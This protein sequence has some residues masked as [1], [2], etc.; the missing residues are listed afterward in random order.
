VV[1]RLRNRHGNAM[2]ERTVLLVF[3]DPVGQ[4]TTSHVPYGYVVQLIDALRRA[5]VRSIS[6]QGAPASD[7]G[8]SHSLAGLLLEPLTVPRVTVR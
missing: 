8:G 7:Q 5:G 1:T 2:T 6:L 4:A 3:N